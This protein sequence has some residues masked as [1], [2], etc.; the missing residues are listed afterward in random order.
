MKNHAERRLCHEEII[1]NNLVKAQKK[2]VSVLHMTK[3][4]EEMRIIEIVLISFIR[5]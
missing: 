5:K 2:K 3:I 4:L 1:K